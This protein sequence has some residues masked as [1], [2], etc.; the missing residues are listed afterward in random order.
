MNYKEFIEDVTNMAAGLKYSQVV[1]LTDE[2]EADDTVLMYLDRLM[3]QIKEDAYHN[4]LHYTEV[5]VVVMHEHPEFDDDKLRK[6]IV[7]GGWDVIS[8]ESNPEVKD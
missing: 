6:F 8:Y 2:I 1:K 5:K 3:C 7:K 4:R